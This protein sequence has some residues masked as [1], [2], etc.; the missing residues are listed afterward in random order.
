MVPPG[1][2]G[3]HVM[4]TWAVCMPWPS[5]TGT[6][7]RGPVYKIVPG[8]QCTRVPRCTRVPK[9]PAGPGFRRIPSGCRGPSLAF[10]TKCALNW[11]WPGVD[12]H[13]CAQ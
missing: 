12:F 13:L 4:Q 2:R 8:C 1:H 10:S 3:M 9:Y 5:G 6:R 7:V 11:N